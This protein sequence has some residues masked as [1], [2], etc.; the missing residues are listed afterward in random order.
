MTKISKQEVQKIA[1]MSALELADHEIEP[2]MKRLEE[3][4][5]YAER[6]TQIAADIDKQM[7]EGAINVFRQDVAHAFDAQ[8]ILERA[9]EREDNF[10]VVPSIIEDK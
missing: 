9:P 3:V 10:Y 6:V 4:L 1:R 5:T 8:P 7:V 2:M